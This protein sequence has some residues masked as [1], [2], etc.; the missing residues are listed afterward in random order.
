MDNL[1]ALPAPTTQTQV[2]HWA[3]AK[4]LCETVS[5]AEAYRDVYDPGEDVTQ[6]HYL[7]GGRLLKDPQ[8]GEIVRVIALPALVEIG[9]DKSHAL[10]RLLQT[11]DADP[12]DY[13]GADGAYLAPADL[14]KL[15]LEKRRLIRRMHVGRSKDGAIFTTDIELEPKHPALQLLAQI[16][17]WV[18]P[19]T[20]TVI[21]NETI[22]NHIA[23]ASKAAERLVEN[24][25]K[26]AI[27]CKSAQQMRRAAGVDGN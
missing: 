23:I 1:P 9:V 3:F 12:T 24:Q 26:A 13:V 22:V 25:R 7:A 17:Q 18:K 20:T 11:I 8:I 16:Q 2:Q 15:P 5:V 4:R 21:N 19:G 14:R 10:T 27:E 6:S